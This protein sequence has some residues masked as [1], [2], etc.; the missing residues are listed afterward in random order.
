MSMTCRPATLRAVCAAALTAAVALPLTFAAAEPA[1]ARG[2]PGH[3]GFAYGGGY[4]P[5]PVLPT[6]PTVW[7]PPI[8]SAVPPPMATYAQIP[9]AMGSLPG[10]VW[11]EPHWVDGGFVGGHW[12]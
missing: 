5:P 9:P 10:S 11:V 7:S 3:V 2:A 6:P 1:W 4:V 12:H 8:V